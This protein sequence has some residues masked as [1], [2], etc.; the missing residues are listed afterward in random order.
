MKRRLTGLQPSGNITI[1][2]YL[3]AL[4]PML[5]YQ[6]QYDSFVFVADL[7]AITVQQDPKKLHENV[8]ELVALLL[9]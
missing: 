9:A 6:N 2:N 1:G 5:N 7:H 4:K 8:R 3:R